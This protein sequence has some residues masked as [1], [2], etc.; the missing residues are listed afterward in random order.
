MGTVT[1]PSTGGST[2]TILGTLTEASTYLGGS[3]AFRAKWNSAS[4]DSKASAL[5]DAT[6]YMNDLSWKADVTPSTNQT[7]I[8]ASYMLAGFFI[9]NPQGMGGAGGSS[10]SQQAVQEV[11]DTTRSVSF[12]YSNS[13]QQAQ[14]SQVDA[15]PRDILA[16]IKPFLARGVA[17]TGVALPWASGTDGESEFTEDKKFTLSE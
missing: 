11:R 9:V 1:I 14:F 4:A 13:L 7:I 8:E 3:F 5:V 17:R 15:L 6:R 10:A 2:Y 12:Y 16:K